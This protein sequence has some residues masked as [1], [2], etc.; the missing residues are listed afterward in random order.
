M[1]AHR[2]S[3]D[4]HRRKLERRARDRVERTEWHRVVFFNQGLAQ[5]TK[6]YLKQVFVEGKL[7]I[8]KW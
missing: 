6:Q 8:R 4:C 2:H 3:R 1:A 7:V 5:I